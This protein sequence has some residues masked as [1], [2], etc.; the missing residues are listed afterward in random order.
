[1]SHISVYSIPPFVGALL[2]FFTG[3]FVLLKD[4]HSKVNRSLFFLTT[5]TFV[6]LCGYAVMYS[7]TSEK[8]AFLCAKCVY[9]GTVFIPVFFHHF[10]INYL[11]LKNNSGRIILTYLVG[12]IFFILLWGTNTYVAGVQKFFWGYHTKVGPAHIPYQIF[13]T[14]CFARCLYLLWVGYKQ[15]QKKSYVEANRVKYLFWAFFVSTIASLDFLPDYGIPLYPV[16]FLFMSGWVIITAYAIVRHQ[17]LDIEVVIKRTIVFAGL[18]LA[19]YAVIAT[20]AYLGAAL[21]EN[22]IQNRWLA[23]VPSVI[24]IVLMLRPLET[25]LRNV[26]DKFLFQKKYDY[27][28][29]L[30]KFSEEVLTFIDINALVERT[31]ETLSNGIKLENASI[32]LYDAEVSEYKLRSSVGIEAPKLAIKDTESLITFM[33]KSKK[34]VLLEKSSN[35]KPLSNDMDHQLSA[36]RGA[37]AIPLIYREGMIGFLSL[38]KKKS[39]EDFIPEDIDIL[40]TLSQTLSIAISNALLFEEL[41]ETQAQAAQQEKMAV[42]GTL[43]AGIN[44]EIC[45]PL[46]IVRGQCE[47][48]L[49]NSDEGI[50]D[51]KPPVEII[52]KAKNI[53][54]KVIHETDRATVITRKLSSFSKPAKGVIHDYVDLEAQLDKVI[55]LVKHELKLDNIVI[56]KN[57]TENL[58][59]I[60]ADEKQIQEIL[61][62]IIRN[63]A[64]AIKENGYIN[65]DIVGDEKYVYVDITDSGEGIS[66][67]NLQKIFN[68]FFT[69]KEPGKGTGLGLFIVKQIVEKNGGRISVRSEKGKGTTF[70]LR[71]AATWPEAEEQK[72][73]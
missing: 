18:F 10:T 35:N 59:C 51:S 58:P 48:F 34:Y 64:Q 26:T 60:A 71:F 30:R 5:S 44:H 16:G 37:F 49:L 19:S 66:K 12:S 65:I 46:G 54:K 3:L 67:E 21:F 43:S 22:F 33:K 20:F 47:M 14:I 45:N 23:M 15:A 27:R 2:L 52:E 57:V 24:I 62:N 29:I 32:Y 73:I 42:I 25:F 56:C 11:K 17:L 38:G 40:I 4:F 13:F 53:M 1:M 50:Y 36:L 61:F 70:T 9:T 68:P 55:E 6:W 63:G 39:D 7:L 41:S 28:Q 69:T 72:T 8:Q 31:I